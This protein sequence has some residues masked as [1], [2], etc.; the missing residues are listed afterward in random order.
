MKENAMIPLAVLD[1]LAD[2]W[3][4]S[5]QDSARKYGSRTSNVVRW[6]AAVRSWIERRGAVASPAS[7][8]PASPAATRKAA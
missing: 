3:M 2:D 6:T 1:I 4:R 5:R 7:L 8:P